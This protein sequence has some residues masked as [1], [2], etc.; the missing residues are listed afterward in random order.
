MLPGDLERFRRL[1]APVHEAE[2]PSW[3]RRRVTWPA[4]EVSC[5]RCGSAIT[6][7]EDGRV[8]HIG[9]DGQLSQVLGTVAP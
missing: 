9:D 3:M 7:L 4:W 6:R 1:I 5:E 8:V 2:V